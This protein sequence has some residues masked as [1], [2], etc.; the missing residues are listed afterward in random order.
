MGALVSDHYNNM[1]RSA[2][3]DPEQRT[4]LR[5]AG[6]RAGAIAGIT[7]GGA[8]IAAALL[9]SLLGGQSAWLPFRCSAALV[10][11]T[12]AMSEA[13]FQRAPV[14]AG[15]AIH[16]AVSIALGCVFQLVCHR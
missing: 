15:M 7:G 9:L 11:G 12:A 1:R 5:H 6:L 3:F 4:F 8:T 16:L 10:Y 2:R 13:G 14:A